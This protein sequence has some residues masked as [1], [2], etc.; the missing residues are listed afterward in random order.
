MERRDPYTRWPE[1][2]LIPSGVPHTILELLRNEVVND[3][4]AL[5][6]E[7][8]NGLH[9]DPDSWSGSCSPDGTRT[10]MRPTQEAMDAM[11]NA[12]KD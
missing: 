12:K 2:R 4:R 9:A 5:S 3:C 6:N 8:W 7:E 10:V 1:V 11:L